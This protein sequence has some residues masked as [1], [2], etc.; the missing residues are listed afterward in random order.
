[1]KRTKLLL[2]TLSAVIGLF[3]A[4]AQAELRRVEVTGSELLGVDPS[5]LQYQAIYGVLHFTLDPADNSNQKIV[6]IRLAPTNTEGLVEFSTDFKLLLPRR[7]NISST[8]MYHVNNRGGSRLPPEIALDHPLALQGHSFLATGWIAE[9][10]AADARLR[11]QVPVVTDNG[12]PVTGDVRYEIV[13]DRAV[14]IVNVAG[15]GH[16]AYTPT[17]SGIEHARLTVRALQAD[18]RQ[19]VPRELFTVATEP[20]DDNLQPQV[21]LSVEGGFQPGMIYELIYQAK[22]PVLSGAGLAGIR[23]IV[24][25]IRQQHEALG[26]LD[27]PQITHAVAWGYSQSGRLLRQFLYQGFNEDLQGDQVFDGV[28]PLIAGAGFGMFNQRFAMPTRT[29][30]QHENDRYPNDFFPFTYGDSADPYS[31]RV[32]GILKKSR[33]S[34][35]EPKLMHIQTTNEYWL[36]AGSLAHTDPLGQQDADIPDNVRFYT[37][38]GSPHSPGN[39]VVGLPTIGQLPGNPNFWTPIADSLLSAMVDWVSENSEPPP[40]VYPLISDGSLQRSHLEDGSI[41][42]TVWRSIQGI[43]EPHT[44]YQVIHIDAGPRFMTHGIA[45]RV[46]PDSAGRY[47]ALAPATGADNN[48]LAAST[49]LPPVTSVPLA[50]FVAWNLRS[51]ASGASTELAR[52][53]GGWIALEATRSDAETR[54]DP[55]PAISTLYRDDRDY[56]Q[57]YEAATDKLIEDGYLLPAFKQAIMAMGTVALETEDLR[58]PSP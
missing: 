2:V 43:N 16:L 9:L 47:V 40:S 33:E 45:D 58:P 18:M 56:L 37:I 17:A 48:D 32:D 53:T 19:P 10:T 55:R 30:G 22:D 54:G 49:I 41:N 50:T 27:M 1:M 7:G 39:G 51:Q 13:P 57:Q 8:L 23:D 26:E 5:P 20:R 28:V 36:R 31:G 44:M 35:T 21:N 6:D 38:G 25:A 11:L 4:N 3:V 24:S 29:N 34:G 52:L 14:D 42:P 12:N 15:S 46:I